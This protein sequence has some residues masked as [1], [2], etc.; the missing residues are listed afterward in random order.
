MNRKL[1]EEQAKR[2]LA[3]DKRTPEIAAEFGINERTV[4]HIKAGTRWTHL[5]RQEKV[6]VIPDTFEQF[7]SRDP[8]GCWNW[9]GYISRV[10]YG[11]YRSQE[12]HR[13]A[14]RRA[15]REEQPPGYC[16]C[17]TCDN[18]RC[19]NPDHLFLG[20]YLDNT[21]DMLSKGRAAWQS[22]PKEQV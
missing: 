20:T 13:V 10:G 7:I 19:V 21:R 9:T 18:R 17:H 22:E 11:R 15:G 1:T 16:I 8:G 2:V 14:W 3:S 5:E 4:L 12:A 6:R